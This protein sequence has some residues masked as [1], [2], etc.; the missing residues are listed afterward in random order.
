[1][2][3]L[4]HEKNDSAGEG[5]Y[6]RQYSVGPVVWGFRMRECGSSLTTGS[7]FGKRGGLYTFTK[8]RIFSQS[9]AILLHA[10]NRDL[11]PRLV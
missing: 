7:F 1:M 11:V 10:V 3:Y 8:N 6:Q 5:R 2:I 9:H 4:G